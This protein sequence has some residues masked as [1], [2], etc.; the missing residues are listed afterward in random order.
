MFI[1]TVAQTEGTI[2]KMYNVML[3]KDNP[4]QIILILYSSSSS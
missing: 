1:C 2:V 4:A 3:L